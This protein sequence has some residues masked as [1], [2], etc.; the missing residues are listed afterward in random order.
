MDWVTG[1]E[2]WELEQSGP[3]VPGI[4]DILIDLETQIE[5][6]ELTLDDLTSLYEDSPMQKNIDFAEIITTM[7]RTAGINVCRTACNAMQWKALGLAMNIVRKRAK[8]NDESDGVERLNNIKADETEMALPEFQ[9]LLEQQPTD[10]ER[11]SIYVG[12]TNALEEHCLTHAQSAYDYPSSFE[13]AYDRMIELKRPMPMDKLTEL[14]KKIGRPVE[15][16][17]RIETQR[18]GRE[19]AQMIEAKAE[20]LELVHLDRNSLECFDQMNA[21]E[22]HNLLVKMA[23]GLRDRGTRLALYAMETRDAGKSA[24]FLSD[25]AVIDQAYD[26]LVKQ[27]AAHERGCTDEL[28]ALEERGVVV[29]IPPKPRQV[30]A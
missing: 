26:E 13:A 4:E 19:H 21:A 7:D 25:A 16:L 3:T 1:L 20:V 27:I 6:G 17:E 29:E 8:Q 2:N 18:K 5:R 14:A 11:L 12:L 23:A 24:M 15:E 28:R 22:R 9:A 10:E 30:A